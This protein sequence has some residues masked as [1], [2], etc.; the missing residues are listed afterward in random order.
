[1]AI[2]H[3][4][5]WL[6]SEMN[7]IFNPGN[8]A[9]T[10]DADKNVEFLVGYGLKPSS[11]MLGKRM[12]PA[13]VAVVTVAIACSLLMTSVELIIVHIKFSFLRCLGYGLTDYQKEV[14]STHTSILSQI[15]KKVNSGR[16]GDFLM[17]RVV[18]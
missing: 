4:Q 18:I 11:V 9:W 16:G 17:R 2:D 12:L 13:S 5:V 10:M 3:F 7:T 15:I 14:H 6:D 8:F 1:M